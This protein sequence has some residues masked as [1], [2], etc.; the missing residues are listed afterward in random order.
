VVDKCKEPLIG[1]NQCSDV[2]GRVMGRTCKSFVLLISNDF[3]KQVL[4]KIRGSSFCFKYFLLYILFETVCQYD[5][6]FFSFF[7]PFFIEFKQKLLTPLGTVI[8]CIRNCVC[9]HVSLF[10]YLYVP[11]FQRKMTRAINTKVGI[12][13]LYGSHYPC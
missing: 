4:R 11:C 5:C 3:L 2:I 9:V 6:T 8:G 12:D 7:F 13:V 10:V 1:W